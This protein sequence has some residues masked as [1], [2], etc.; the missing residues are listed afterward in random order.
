VQRCEDRDLS[1]GTLGAL[2]QRAWLH[3]SCP[4]AL[5][6]SVDALLG[7]AQLPGVGP[8]AAPDVR[9]MLQVLVQTANPGPPAN[10]A[11]CCLW[12]W[13]G[14]K[15]LE[16]KRRAV[17]DLGHGDR[18]PP[19]SVHETG[20]KLNNTNRLENTFPSAGGQGAWPPECKEHQ[21]HF[22]TLP[23]LAYLAHN[24]Q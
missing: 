14:R 17:S 3:A 23:H 9:V 16:W 7:P 19:G 6:H 1:S 20:S 11:L 24:L 22:C 5:A 8:F 12:D 21:T 4:V 15:D 18:R 2:P 10:E 13:R